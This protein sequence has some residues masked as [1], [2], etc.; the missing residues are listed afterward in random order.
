MTKVELEKGIEICK[1]WWE[2]DLNIEIDVDGGV[3]IF[4]PDNDSY[5]DR[6]EGQWYSS[7][8]RILIRPDEEH[9]TE[10]FKEILNN[11]EGDSFTLDEA[12]EFIKNYYEGLL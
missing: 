4:S 8:V 10:E 3:I 2:S 11:Y 7:G 9:I 5:W 1:N 12:I 6:E